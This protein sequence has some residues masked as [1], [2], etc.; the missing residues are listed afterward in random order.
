MVVTEPTDGAVVLRVL[1]GD[2]EAFSLLVDRHHARLARYATHLLGDRAEAEEVVQDAFVR[3]FRSLAKY[4]NREQFGAWLLRI[5]V[6]RCR[7][8]LARDARRQA[9]AAVWMREV[10][11]GWARE[12]EPAFDP[13]AGAA[14]EQLREELA[15]ALAQLP[16]D[17]REAVVLR[18]ADEL[19]YEEIAAITGAGVSALKMR[20]KRG[21]ER[22]R[23]LLEASRARS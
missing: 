3:A 22:L 17:Q 21:C 1:A 6:N 8:A 20:V 4:E 15:A 5:L 18:H 10:A 23:T 13:A 9:A 2:V 16:S 14:A 19:G 11:L 12:S 7:T